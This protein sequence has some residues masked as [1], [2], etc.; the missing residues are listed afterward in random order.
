MI[1]VNAKIVDK[2]VAY[3]TRSTSSGYELLVFDHDE[4]Y[5]DA[6]TQVPA[7]TVAENEAP[8]V[9]V[10]REI[11]EESGLGDLSPPAKIDEYVFWRETHSQYNRRHVFHLEAKSNV[12][13]KWTHLVIGDGIDK[14]LRFHYFWIDLKEA[15]G[16]LSGRLDDSIEKLQDYLKIQEDLE[17][18][19]INLEQDRETCLEFRIDSYV[20][21]FGSADNFYKEGGAEHYFDWLKNKIEKNPASAI[22]VKFQGKII[23]QMEMGSFKKTAET[24]MVNLYYLA[25]EFRGL[26]FSA[27]L[28]SYAM[29]FMKECRY[30]T[31]RLSV[32]PTNK[33]AVR[34]YEKQGWKNLGP[35]PDYPEVHFMEKML[36]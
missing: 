21:S 16:R 2:A 36:S 33:R 22:H 24:G 31:A 32:S 4:E 23:G 26:G 5:S 8:A 11:L 29:K 13:D 19:P 7:G 3:I 17:F 35:R 25:P 34:Y 15:K 27:H 30:K 14:G 1:D 10:V 12:L 9:T 18:T 6:G 20:C 28:D